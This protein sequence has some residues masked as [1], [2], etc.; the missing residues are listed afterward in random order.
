MLIGELAIIHA[1]SGPS[2]FFA[3]VRRRSACC[4]LTMGKTFF[5]FLDVISYLPTICPNVAFL[6]I[7][8]NFSEAP[9]QAFSK[10]LVNGV[11]AVDWVRS[12]V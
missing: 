8:T 3:N 5:C 11:S 7:E 10:F 9:L 2:C 4:E 6:N 12:M 1:K